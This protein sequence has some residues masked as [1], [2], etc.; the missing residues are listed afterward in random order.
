MRRMRSRRRHFGSHSAGGK[1]RRREGARLL[2]WRLSQL[3]K[4]AF[5]QNLLQISSLR[6]TALV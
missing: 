6:K 2:S 1:A 4:R 5:V 3:F